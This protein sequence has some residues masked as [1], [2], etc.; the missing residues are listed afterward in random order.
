MAKIKA[1]K[2]QKKK[3]N[4]TTLLVVIG[5]VLIAGII[6]AVSSGNSSSDESGKVMTLREARIAIDEQ[7]VGR[8]LSPTNTGPVRDGYIPILAPRLVDENLKLPSYAYTNPITLNAYKFAIEHPEV[9]EQIPCYCGCGSHGSVVSEGKPHKSIRDCFIS[10]SGAFDDH[11]S[12][13][14]MCVGDATRTQ[15]YVGMN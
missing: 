13:C 7:Y 2:P 6:Y 11:G 14:D 1:R 3:G 8:G 5:L 9:L 15:K 10:D 12:F 4:N